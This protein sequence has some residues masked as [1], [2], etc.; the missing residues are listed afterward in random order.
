MKKKKYILVGDFIIAG[1]GDRHYI[2]ANKLIDLYKLDRE[3]CI[4][5]DNYEQFH[6][7]NIEDGLTV[8]EPRA[9][10]NYILEK[11]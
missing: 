4:L 6:R 8:L 1:D 10:G 7:L 5:V 3:E 9:S 2:S 11:L